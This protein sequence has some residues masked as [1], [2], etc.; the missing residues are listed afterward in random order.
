MPYDSIAN[1]AMQHKLP[2]DVLTE[3]LLKQ[4]WDTILALIVPADSDATIAYIGLDGK[5]RYS[6]AE[7][8]SYVTAREIIEYYCPEKLPLYDLLYSSGKYSPYKG[9]ES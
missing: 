3:R 1:L 9:G 5:A 2:V 6:C 7:L 4:H 8:G